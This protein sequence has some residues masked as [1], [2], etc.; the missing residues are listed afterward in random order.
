MK[1]SIMSPMGAVL[2]AEHVVAQ[3]LAE[4]ADPRQA[5]AHALRAIGD[6]LG[7]RLGSVWEPSPSEPGVLIC[8]QVW[9]ADGVDV[10]AF[11]RASRRL[12][13][14]PG[15]GLPGRVWQTGEPA[16]IRDVQ[17]DH[18]FPRL[19]AARRANLHAAFCFPI[20]SAAG[21]LG[22][23]EF[24][25]AEPREPDGQLL[26]TM[27]VLG[28]QLGQ[29]HERIRAAQALAANNA[30]HQAVLDAA[31]DSIV[32]MDHRGLVVE[33]NPAAERTFRYSS[34]QAVGREMAELIIP[35]ELREEH[36]QGLRRY[37]AGERA[38]LLDRRIETDAVRADGE[39]FPV[40]LTITRID[41]PGAPMFTG[42]LRDI[43]ERRRTDAELRRSRAR[44]VEAA[45]AARRRI[46]RDLHDGAQQR[47]VGV[48]MSLRL[49]GAAL[50]TDPAAARALLDEAGAD[51]AEAIAELRELARGIHPAILTEGGLDPALRAL[52][53]RSPVPVTIAAVP[54][55]RFPAAI[56]AAAYFVVSEGLT[57]AARHAPDSASTVEVR[58]DEDRLV[59]EVRD[60]GPGGADVRGGGLQGLADR[61]NA[62][63]GRLTIVSPPQAGTTLRA[64]LPCAS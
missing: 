16:W 23:V 29:V 6:S 63:S 58:D 14:A 27:S 25:A 48:A 18:N 21:T 20:R 35:P 17:L 41:V 61:V 53:R 3:R 51:L 64:E 7:W 56:E 28:D 33:F 43:T 12:R 10:D 52:A 11:E 36:R 47:L 24:F 31:L 60:T 62:L 50:E 30:R 15:E 1:T 57:N 13:L 32:T 19:D 5:L 38:D 49:A 44:I 55:R 9:H 4:T 40:E 46:E 2:R 54:T 34:E 37:L 8:V 22:V 39:R 26:A 45:D 42:H 59:V